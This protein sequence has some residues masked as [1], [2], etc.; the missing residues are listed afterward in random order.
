MSTG[1]LARAVSRWVSIPGYWLELSAGGYLYHDTGQSCQ[2]VGIYTRILARAVS[3]SVSTGILV[4][5]VSRWVSIPG[6]W[7][8]LSAGG[9]L[10]HDTGQSCQ[11]VGIYTRILARAVSRSVSTGILV[12]AVSRW[13]SIPGY[14][15][16]LSAGGYLYHDTGQSCQQ[17]GIYRDTGQSCQHVNI[18]T[19]ILTRAVR[20]W[21]TNVELKKAI[22]R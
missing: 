7:L 2:Q 8:E 14:W 12:R 9:Y 4:R 5:A 22:A 3:R 11:Q 16:E 15:L 6:Y 17:V 10:Y 20:R 13:V 21:V 18:Y 1:I 19:V